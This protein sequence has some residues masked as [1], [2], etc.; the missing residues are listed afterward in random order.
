VIRALI[1]AMLLTVTPAQADTIAVDAKSSL[2]AKQS[3][4]V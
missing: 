3:N 1:G 2:R 4:L